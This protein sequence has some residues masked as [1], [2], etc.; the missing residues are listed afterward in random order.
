MS[1]FI[2]AIICDQKNSRTFRQAPHRRI[3]F[4]MFPCQPRISI[5]LAISRLTSAFCDQNRYHSIH[6]VT[7][8]DRREPGCVWMTQ[9]MASDSLT[10]SK[11]SK[12]FL[13]IFAQNLWLLGM[14][15]F[16][17]WRALRK[18]VLVRVAM[19]EFSGRSRPT[20]AASMASSPMLYSCGRKWSAQHGAPEEWTWSWSLVSSF[21][22]LFQVD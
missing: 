8:W 2:R 21:L 6:R 7:P 20:Q 10:V 5:F 9:A 12:C 22:G 17:A 16:S 11:V 13:V 18:T 1:R 19:V 14:C 4:S 15:L 3:P